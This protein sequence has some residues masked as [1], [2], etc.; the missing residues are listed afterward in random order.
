VFSKYYQDELAFMRELGR[1]FAKAHPEAAPFLSGPGGDPDV[2]RLMEGFA[3]L[4]GRIREKL[5]DEIPEISH[6]LLEVFFPHYLRPIPSMSV[7]A[8]EPGASNESR[9]IPAGADL[10]SALV[11]G[12]ECGFKTVYDVDVMPLKVLDVRVI[13]GSP[14]KLAMSFEIAQGANLAKLKP[15]KLR[16]HLAGDVTTSRNLYLCLT[17]LLRRVRARSSSAWTEGKD[18]NLMGASCVPVG[19]EEGQTLLPSPKVTFPGFRL[20][21][22]YFVFPRKFL[23]LDLVGLDGLNQMGDTNRFELFFEL[24]RLPQGMGPVSAEDILLHCTPVVNLFPHDA[25]PVRVNQ[26]RT[27]YLL[28]PSGDKREHYEVY[29]VDRVRGMSTV[30]GERRNFRSLHAAAHMGDEENLFFRTRTRFSVV[31]DGTDVYLSIVDPQAVEVMP[32]VETISLELTCSN[33]QLPKRLGIGDIRP[34]R[35][36]E[37]RFGEY[38]NIIRP[39]HSIP[40]P[41]GEDLYWRLLTHLSLNYQ[42]LLTTPNLRNLLWLYNFRAR[43]DHQAGQAFQ[44]MMQ[45]IQEVRARPVTQLLEGTPVRG[46][47]IFLGLDEGLFGGEGQ[48]ALF[49][50]IL[51]RFFSQYVTLNSFSHLV[52]KGLNYGG[53]YSWSPRIGNRIIL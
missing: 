37:S 25:D 18:V 42:S 46:L 7:V 3:F 17:R 32:D 11:D 52:V 5:D 49:G 34:P 4:T 47:E 38:R 28:T 45:G 44:R 19:L 10:N 1:E 40:P 36:T 14:P 26:E 39:T 22:E 9:H 23:F 24:A 48:I 29:S 43:V 35:G 21:L 16:L 51:N 8:F 27:E 31:A 2:E 53:I 41:L 50:T 15:E 13:Q 20:L 33:R 30:T 12:V 6:S